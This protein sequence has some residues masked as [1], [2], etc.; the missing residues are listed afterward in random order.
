MGGNVAAIAVVM[1]VL[2]HQGA[3]WTKKCHSIS[4]FWRSKR[5]M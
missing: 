2:H 4:S 5:R 3:R 1:G